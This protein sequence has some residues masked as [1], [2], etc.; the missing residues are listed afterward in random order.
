MTINDVKRGSDNLS[1]RRWE[2][3]GDDSTLEKVKEI[4]LKLFFGTS[5]NLRG[6]LFMAKK[7]N[8]WMA[9]TLNETYKKLS[10]DKILPMIR[11]SFGNGFHNNG[12][13]FH[14]EQKVQSNN[15]SFLVFCTFLKHHI[16]HHTT[17][18]LYFQ[19]YI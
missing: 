8:K 2:G 10:Q 14:L 19:L 13:L 11:N 15:Y 6:I 12:L 1:A 5:L 7:V 9:K 16:K 18:F 4:Y 17:K 3:C